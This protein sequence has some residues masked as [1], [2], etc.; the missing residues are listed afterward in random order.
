MANDAADVNADPGMPTRIPATMNDKLIDA[1]L[2]VTARLREI[3][4]EMD[5]L[6]VDKVDLPS[7]EG[8]CDSALLNDVNQ[9]N[10]PPPLE[11][12]W[13]DLDVPEEFHVPLSVLVKKYPARGE[14]RKV[15]GPGTINGER[16][17]A[18]KGLL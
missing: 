4:G 13:G 9:F 12:S 7:S 17:R 8:E 15:T 2:S 1:L 18:S 16:R 6:V 14:K 10:S 5:K 3:R 11:L